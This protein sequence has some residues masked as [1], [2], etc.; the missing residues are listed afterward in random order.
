MRGD[1]LCGIL[2]HIGA[3]DKLDF[4]D[5]L[6]LIGH[7]GPDSFATHYSPP[8]SLGFHRLSII[9]ISEKSNQPM[10]S[11]DSRF[12]IIFNGE[13]YNFVQIRNQLIENGHSFE[14][15]GD[16]EVI[17]RSYIEWGENCLD[18][19]N[20][21]FAFAIFDNE[22]EE[23]FIARDRLG[24]KPLF[25][26]KS[27][28]SFTFSSEPKSLIRATKATFNINHDSIVSYLCFRYPVSG[29]SFFEGIESLSPG[30]WMKLDGFRVKETHKYWSLRKTLDKPKI[31]DPDEAISLVSDH[32][33]R[34]VELR[35]VADVPVGA[36]LSGGVDSS[37]I[38]AIMANCSDSPIPTY[39]IGFPNSGYNEFEFSRLV[40]EQYNT[41]HTEIMIGMDDYLETLES[42]IRLKDAPLGVPNEVPLFLMSKI[43]KNDI[44]VVLSGEGADEIFGGYGR[45]FRSSED[46]RFFEKWS[47]DKFE[48][49]TELGR[50]LTEIYG[51]PFQSEVD[52][53]LHLYRYTPV[54]W[55]QKLIE[56]SLLE[57]FNDG[58]SMQRFHDIFSDGG[59][60]DH[61]TQYM[62]VFEML[63]LPGLLQ[64]VDIT[65][66][67]ASVEARV[68]FVDHNLVELAFRID[69][70]LKIRWNNGPVEMVGVDSSEYHDTPKWIL[71]KVASELLPNSIIERK[72]VGFPVPL[73]DWSEGE[74]SEI[75]RERILSGEMIRSGIILKEGVEELF[76]LVSKN[77]QEA[78]IIWMLYN[79]EIFIQINRNIFSEI[80]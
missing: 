28:N 49:D 23:T 25:F 61:A 1:N 63:H 36:Y 69:K 62:Y 57:K 52:R 5:A 46:I 35:M 30:H 65:T 16:A 10:H 24:I 50:R 66:M 80:S 74:F 19:F 17:L 47:E 32:L 4:E 48:S 37:L 79:L 22:S 40:S 53:F 14:T 26:I 58:E 29:A 51:G 64:R 3:I 31:S 59:D 38:T 68:P 44:T 34:A 33:K 15:N 77:H 8:F 54:D 70:E 9:D 71:K 55:L 11:P 18:R 41:K 7:R 13:L 76:S 73:A 78:M 12:S 6:A 56:P 45:I 20:G 39:S 67:G 27:E 43:L 21:M 60:L 72:K 42:L 75:A 2:G